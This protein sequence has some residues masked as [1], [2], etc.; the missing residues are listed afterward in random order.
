MATIATANS[1]TPCPE[2][3]KKLS[4]D[5]FV[6]YSN[7]PMWTKGKRRYPMFH[8]TIERREG[9]WG[10]ADNVTYVQGKAK[11]HILGFDRLID[12]EKFIWQGNGFLTKYLSSN[13]R[14]VHISAD[15]N[16]ALI[17]FEKTLFT[18]AG[19][20][21]IARESLLSSTQT[22]QIEQALKDY[23]IPPLSKITQVHP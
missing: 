8:Y 2:L 18:P 17:Y 16:W 9:E 15:N 10:L 20:D 11:K 12:A 22:S 4:G 19:Y 14:I 5:W 1:H 3:L 6:I 13:W 7:F 23:S 21:A